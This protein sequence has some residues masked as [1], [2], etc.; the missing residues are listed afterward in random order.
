MTLRV[1]MMHNHTK[2][3]EE[4]LSSGEDIVRTNILWGFGPSLRPWP[5]RQPS[6]NVK[7]S[8]STLVCDNAHLYQTKFGCKRFKNWEDM[9]ESH[10]LRIWPHTVILT[11]KLKIGTQPFPNG[12]THWLWWCI[13]PNWVA[14]GS[15][16]RMISSGQRCDTDRRTT[17]F[18]YT[19]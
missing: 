1:M 6:K 13:I 19:P 12:M 4:R 5:W 2:F 3:H 9:E 15:V 16:V 17:K 8:H 11:L 14:H 18:Q 7:L 10:F